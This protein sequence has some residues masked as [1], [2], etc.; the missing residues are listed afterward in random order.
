MYQNGT[1]RGRAFAVVSATALVVVALG[2]WL[3][4]TAAGAAP[5]ESA[6]ER[7][8]LAAR[9][10]VTYRVYCRTCHG[11][12][13]TGDGPLA[14]LLKAPPRDLT[15]LSRQA[16]G[17]FPED[18]VAAAIDGREL[19]AAHGPREMPIWGEAFQPV[20]WTGDEAAIK[21]KIREVVLY[22]GTLQK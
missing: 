2:G 11:P 17:E 13:G 19:V 8:E 6:A 21:A 14:E 1:A 7:E 15:A 4:A 10:G 9:G 16:G 18:E 5:S 12:T 22:L 20:E 3:V